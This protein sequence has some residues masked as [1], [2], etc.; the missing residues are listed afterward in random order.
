MTIQPATSSMQSRKRRNGHGSV[1]K[2]GHV[3]AP[4][5]RNT[6]RR[7]RFWWFQIL[8]ILLAVALL[9]LW[10]LNV[11]QVLIR[12]ESSRGGAW[13]QLPFDGPRAYSMLKAICD[14]GPRISGS[15]GMRKQ[16]KMLADYFTKR[17]GT[18][19][20]Q[21]FDCRHPETG[22]RVELANLVVNWH[23]DRKERILLCAHYDTRPNCDRDP[24]PAKRR[25]PLTGANDGASGVAVLAE[26]GRHLQPWDGPFGVDFVLFDAEEFLFDDTRDRDLYFLGSK[27][28]ARA[29][30]AN[31]P[32]HRYRA[33]V[34]LDMVGDSDLRFLQEGWS[35]SWPES[36]PIVQSI[37][38]TARRLGVREFVARP[39]EP[40]RDDHLPLY[41]IARIPA[42]DVI[43]FDYPNPYRSSYWH[44]THDT[45]DK[46]SAESLDKVG[47]VILAWL[48]QPS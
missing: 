32:A 19:T 22:E 14:L 42:L 27:Y 24:D 5:Q 10:F 18:V 13:T 12:S 34:V 11:P 40:V 25:L 36:R 29:L 8:A 6:T 39:G 48:R 7:G 41:E 38:R 28:F 3:V 31:P 33:A 37:W 21:E 16:R 4:A 23:P 2:T 20:L 47:S 43:D 30:V 26:L 1:S 15:E 35:L 17:G 45:P 9:L 46:C 44:T